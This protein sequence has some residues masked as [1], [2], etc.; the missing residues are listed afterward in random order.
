MFW[1]RFRYVTLHSRCVPVA[2]DFDELCMRTA[3]P[4]YK[5]TMND[6]KQKKD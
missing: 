1:V 3:N 6:A 2:T 4:K 5:A